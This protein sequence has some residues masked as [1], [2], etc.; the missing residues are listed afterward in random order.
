MTRTMLMLPLLLLAACRGE[1]EV[2][3]R[4]ASVEDVA[5]R[6]ADAGGSDSF[7]RPGKWESQVRVTAFDMPGAPPQMASAMRSMHE[8]ARV[9]TTCLTAEDARRPKEDFFA[10]AGKNC[11]YHH[12]DMSGGKIDAMMQCQGEGVAQ[13][14]TMKGSYSPDDYRMQVSVKADASGGAGPLGAMTMDMQVDARRVGECDGK[15][16]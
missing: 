6:V 10:G 4:N 1:P 8:S 5:A 7:V 15:Q 12:F 11:R 16:G 2:S 9:A 14:M 13:T 3:A